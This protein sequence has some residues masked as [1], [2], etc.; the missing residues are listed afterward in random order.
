MLY[1]L[2]YTRPES[3]SIANDSPDIRLKSSQNSLYSQAVFSESTAETHYT[4]TPDTMHPVPEG[5]FGEMIRIYSPPVEI[6]I[7]IH[8]DPLPFEEKDCISHDKGT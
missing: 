5:Y 1:Q 8:V 4:E 6:S 3:H 7:Q 2:S